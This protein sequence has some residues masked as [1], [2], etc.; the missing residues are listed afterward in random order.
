MIVILTEFFFNIVLDLPMNYSE[1][2]TPIIS[3]KDCCQ[4][5]KNHY[6]TVTS[7]MMC[8]ES[9]FEPNF[10]DVSIAYLLF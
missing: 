2:I 6:V 3:N 1:I 10:C 4:R 5:F 8:A 7:K 9:N